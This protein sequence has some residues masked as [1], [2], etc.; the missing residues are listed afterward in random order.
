[1][2]GEHAAVDAHVVTRAIVASG[3]FYYDLLALRSQR[4]RCDVPIFRLEELY[5]FPS[6]RLRD[7]LARFP[8][9][10]E[11]VWAQEEARNHGAW[12]LL[13]DQLEAVLPAGV[14]LLCSARPTAAPSAGCDPK[15][16]ASE[17]RQV[18]LTALGPSLA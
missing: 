6:D 11:V 7:E 13:R 3:K 14:T 2:I 15:Q 18:A 17:Q 9:L 10:R 12:H 5:P 8:R 4:T 16:H 1:L